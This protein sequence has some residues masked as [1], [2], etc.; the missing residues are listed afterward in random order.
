MTKTKSIL[1]GLLVA[2]TAFMVVSCDKIAPDARFKEMKQPEKE[3][4]RRTVLLED[5]TGVECVN[6]PKAAEAIHEM[7][8]TFKKNLVAVG[9]HGHKGFT[10]E[11]SPLFSTDAAEYYKRFA[12][13]AGLPTGIIN[14]T[15]FPA[16]QT[17][18]IAAYSSWAGFV[19]GILN[20][21]PQIFAIEA[22]ATSDGISEISATVSVKAVATENLPTNLK[23][24]VWVIENG[25]TGVAQSGTPNKLK[26]EHNHV[27]RGALNGTWGESLELNKSYSYKKSLDKIKRAKN[28]R[29]V[30]FVYD[31]DTMEVYEANEVEIPEAL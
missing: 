9:L 4:A 23:L 19:N 5:F 13:G 16:E 8:A 7:Q 14:R 21:K 29:L 31:T 30:S 10:P 6:C 20:T 25:I 2:A 28:C 15:K 22:S 17:L 18:A 1:S 11:N 12:D 27:L 3:M 24:Q 26:Y